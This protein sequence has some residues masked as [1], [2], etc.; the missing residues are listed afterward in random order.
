LAAKNKT[1]MVTKLEELRR[2]RLKESDLTMSIRLFEFDDD[3]IRKE[4]GEN[5]RDEINHVFDIQHAL[6]N[7]IKVRQKADRC[8][9]LQNNLG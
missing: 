6:T 2:L 9:R 5:Q 4:P 8:D 7:G 3:G 1:P